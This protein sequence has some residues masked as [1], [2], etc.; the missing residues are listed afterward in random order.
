MN[1]TSFYLIVDLTVPGLG[2]AS[3]QPASMYPHLVKSCSVFMFSKVR[4]I[5]ESVIVFFFSSI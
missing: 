5:K 1:W 4:N 3:L 2:P